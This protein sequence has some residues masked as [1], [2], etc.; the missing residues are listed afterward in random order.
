[1]YASQIGSTRR[2]LPEIDER[3]L[4][5]LVLDGEIDTPAVDADPGT[6]HL[7]TVSRR[8]SDDWDLMCSAAVNIWL[9][10][11]PNTTAAFIHA[12]RPYIKEPVITRVGGEPLD[13]PAADQAAT[14]VV[15]NVSELT[16]AEQDRLLTWIDSNGGKSRVI[17]TSMR[18]ALP[19]IAAGTFRES[20]YYRLNTMYVD[21]TT[22]V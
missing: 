4:G 11:R 2:H 8:L 5:T 13:L 21:V 16:L 3:R 1:M 14:L 7:R 15:R 10:G 6:Q 17:A 12:L 9:F 20:L 18:S 19:M 22:S